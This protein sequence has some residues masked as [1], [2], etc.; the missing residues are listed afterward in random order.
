MSGI[1]VYG[2][3]ASYEWTAG[4]AVRQSKT[5]SANIINNRHESTDFSAKELNISVASATQIFG[6]LSRNTKHLNVKCTQT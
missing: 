2:Q 4:D 3:E 6:L 5:F 1:T